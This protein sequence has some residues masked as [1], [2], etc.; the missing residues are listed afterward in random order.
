MQPQTVRI[1][2][3]RQ[4][5]TTGVGDLFLHVVVVD[6]REVSPESENPGLSLPALITVIRA[7]LAADTM[8]LVEFNDRLI[9]AGWID[10]QAARYEG[11][12]LTPRQELTFRVTGDFPRLTEQQLPAGVGDVDYALSLAAC[13]P[14]AVSPTEMAAALR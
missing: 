9:E 6:E 5:D 11:R 7:A 12:R 3:E 1:T 10:L 2:S 14:F 8:A 4:L 13:T